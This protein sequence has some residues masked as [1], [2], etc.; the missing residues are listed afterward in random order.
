MGIGA[1]LE[2]EVNGDVELPAGSGAQLGA[3]RRAQITRVAVLFI[4]V[5]ITVSLVIFREELVRFSRFGY[6]GLFVVG[7]LGSATVILPMPGLALAF[8]AGGTFQPLLVGLAYGTGASLGELTGYLAGY[9]GSVVLPEELYAARVV[10]ALHRWG[11]WMIFVL[12]VIPNPAFDIVGIAAG[13]LRIPV[14]QFLAASWAGNVIKASLIA[15]AGGGA[16]G[17]LSPYIERVLSE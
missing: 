6:A 5:A 3:R 7:L 8:A 4:A 14:W 12:A 9:G 2:D 16:I 15:L 10:T 17:A 11:A 1:P 13:A